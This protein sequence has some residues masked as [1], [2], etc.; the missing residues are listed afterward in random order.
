MRARWTTEQIAQAPET[1]AWA[2]LR[3][4]LADLT[5]QK[6]ARA[7]DG[8]GVVATEVAGAAD[9]AAVRAQVV[10]GKRA[11]GRPRAASVWHDIMA[12]LPRTRIQAH[13]LPDGGR[14]WWFDGLRLA[15]HNQILSAMSVA[16]YRVYRY[17]TARKTLMERALAVDPAVA[18]PQTT[19][20]AVDVVLRTPR[21]MDRDNQSPITKH[22]IDALTRT[23]VIPGD[24]PAW[25][26]RHQVWTHRGSFAVAMRLRSEEAVAAPTWDAIARDWQLPD[27]A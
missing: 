12:R 5:P 19:P 13:V 7:A 24:G 14:V 11:V 18:A 8:V 17:K 27:G 22:L 10:A 9:W 6:A 21:T 15:T 16:P 2:A 26:V 23:G 1:P 25:M 3:R 20:F 4:M